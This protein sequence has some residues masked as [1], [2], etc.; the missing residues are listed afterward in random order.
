MGYGEIDPADAEYFEYA[1]ICP[2]GQW[3]F[4]NDRYA[5]LDTRIVEGYDVGIFYKTDNKFGSWDLS[6]R[7]AFYDKY[8]QVPGARTQALIDAAEAGVFPEGFPTPAGFGDLLRQNG[9]QEE[10][11]NASLSWRKGDFGA[12]VSGYYLSDFVQTSLGVREGQEWVIPS[13]TTYN[14]SLDYYFDPFDTDTRLRLGINNF[15][16]ERAPL[17]DRFFGYFADAHRDLGRYWY[18]DARIEFD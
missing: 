14:A 3:Q 6:I 12:R 16:D 9:N 4:V 1:G 17:A 2:V 8:E 5:N 11:Y 13:M 15:T 10:K 18:F 7:G